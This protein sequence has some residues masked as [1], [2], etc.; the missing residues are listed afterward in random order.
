MNSSLLFT[1]ANALAVFAWLVLIISPNQ[2]K[3]IPYLRVLVAGLF[4]GGL[5]II[6]LA[7]GFGNAEGNF[8][9]LESVRSLFQN[10]EFLLAGWVHYLAFDLFIGTWEAEDGWKQQIH[11]LILLPIHLLTFYFGPVGLVLYFLVRG[12]KTKNFNF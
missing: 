12:F 3:V 2:N 5:Y 4:L 8:G 6:S 10:D 7:L 11:R 9:S 1:I